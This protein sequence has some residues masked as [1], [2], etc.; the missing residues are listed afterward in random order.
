MK[1]NQDFYQKYC[2]KFQPKQEWNKKM[3]IIESKLDQGFRLRFSLK[4]AA[5][6][7]LYL[8]H[9]TD[10]RVSFTTTTD[11]IP[12]EV[13]Q[14]FRLHT[15]STAWS[16]WLARRP[17]DTRGQWKWCPVGRFPVPCTCVVLA[18]DPILHCF[19][20]CVDNKNIPYKASDSRQ[21]KGV[22]E[23]LDHSSYVLSYV[24]YFVTQ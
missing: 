3:T 20:G 17:E 24:L 21:N 2:L 19:I 16:A 13:V 14:W 10:R 8:R 15:S 11:V 5:S 22:L 7:H 12:S 4:R 1:W 18:V 23:L 9:V 6:L